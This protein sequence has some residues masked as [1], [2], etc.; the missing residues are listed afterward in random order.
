MSLVEIAAFGLLFVKY[1]NFRIKVKACLTLDQ[2]YRD[3]RKCLFLNSLTGIN[4]TVESVVLCI[5]E[6]HFFFSFSFFL[7]FLLL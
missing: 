2:L 6:P 4:S 1:E 5:K 7:L 3:A